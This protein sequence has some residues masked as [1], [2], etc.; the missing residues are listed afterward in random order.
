MPVVQKLYNAC[1]VSFSSNGPISEEDLER[2]RAILDELKAS[3]VG[4]EQEA[5]LAR[6]FHGSNGRKGRNG[7][8]QYPPAIKYLHLHECDRF[9]IGIFCMP[10]GSIIPLHN[11]PGMTVLSKLLYGS[12]HVRSYD[13][14]DL[15]E[16]S[17]VSKVLYPK[18]GGNIH[19]FKALTSCALFDILSP[20]YS[21]EDGRHCSYFRKSP[22][23]DL[24]SLEELC[25]AEPS[26]VAWLE[27]IQPPEN[28]VVRRGVYK[29]P[30]IRK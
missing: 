25:G 13:W 18:S 26:E 29:G 23:V 21:S 15:P 10:P 27:E 28:F 4:L 6:G 16:C 2:V 12:L 19:C 7:T 9:S 5:Q 14:L 17:D 3:N 24:P 8:H 20:P 30:T 22:R 11:H 1:K